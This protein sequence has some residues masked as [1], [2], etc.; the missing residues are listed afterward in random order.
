MIEQLKTIR[1]GVAEFAEGDGQKGLGMILE[2]VTQLEA[3][4]GEQEPVAWIDGGD[5]ELMRKHGRGCIAWGQEQ[6]NAKTPLY[7]APVA[8]QPTFDA[9]RALE[10]IEALLS[11]IRR[12]APSLSGKVMGFAEEVA[13]AL[14]DKVAQQPQT[15]DTIKRQAQKIAE[16]TADRDGWIEA[17]AR[18]H[19]EYHDFRKAAPQQA[20]AVPPTHV[21]VPVDVLKAA[22]ESLGNFVSDH[23]WTDA[24]MQAM[25]NLDAAIAQQK[26]GV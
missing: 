5:L 22:S 8:Q 3:M 18:L 13:A 10:A 1:A 16:L 2:A 12:D 25:D 15:E 14:R 7:A 20:E 24:D 6:N 23:G 17:H 21:L 26:G 9:R 19:R 11:N 4:V